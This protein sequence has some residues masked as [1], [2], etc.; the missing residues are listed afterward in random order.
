MAKVEK[1]GSAVGA[2][3][4]AT[5]EFADQTT[6]QTGKDGADDEMNTTDDESPTTPAVGAALA[7]DPPKRQTRRSVGAE[8]MNYKFL[9]N[10]IPSK[11]R[12]RLI[13]QI[14]REWYYDYDLLE[15]HHGHVSIYR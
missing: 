4:W 7:A 11:P 6:K 3:L 2:S 5:P 1:S 8:G 13:T 12:G 15:E 9:L 10:Q 14:H